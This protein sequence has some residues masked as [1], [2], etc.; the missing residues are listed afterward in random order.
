MRK[1]FRF[2]VM[3]ALVGALIIIPAFGVLPLPDIQAIAEVSHPN[4]IFAEIYRETSPSVVAI[5]VQT[6]GGGGR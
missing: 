2:I 5:S 1:L 4:D 3:P 6:E